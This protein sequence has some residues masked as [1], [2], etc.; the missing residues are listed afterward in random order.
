[1]KRGSPDI[2]V[3]AVQEALPEVQ[4]RLTKDVEALPDGNFLLT[5]Q[6]SAWTPPA[7]AQ[8]MELQP[9]RPQDMAPFLLKQGTAAIEAAGTGSLPERQR[10]FTTQVQRFLD[11]LAQRGPDDPEGLAL[12]RMLGNPMEAALAAE[13]LAAGQMP[14]P[15]RLLEQRMEHV[16]EDYETEHGGEF[17]AQRFGAWLLA[18]RR[19]GAPALNLSG[20]ETEAAFLARHRLL[21]KGAGDDAG[22]R[23]RHDKILEWFVRPAT[24][25]TA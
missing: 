12:R 17:P 7:G 19:S 24:P 16:G 25:G 3:D 11:S 5:T 2:F 22:W 10:A 21:R 1:V 23:F 9:L 6:P 14:D 20:F 8:V 15:H 18:W 13:L 4:P